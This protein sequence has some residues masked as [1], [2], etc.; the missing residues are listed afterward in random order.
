M[1]IVTFW[2]PFYWID[3]DLK[4]LTA[5]ISVGTVYY[6]AP[7]LAMLLQLHSH[8]ELDDINRKLNLEIEERRK[9]HELLLKL[10]EN[11]PGMLYQ[12]QMLDEG[13]YEF[14]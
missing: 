1:G 8:E 14:P 12:F 9:G 11:I 6:L 2:Q 4:G 13:R 7:R 10:S 5:L 3:A